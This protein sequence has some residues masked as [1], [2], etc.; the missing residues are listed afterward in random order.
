MSTVYPAQIDTS[1]TL[2]TVQDNVTVV[3]ASTVNTLRDAILA[4]ENAL[5]IQPASVY[6]NVSTRL[7][8]IETSL[9]NLIAGG[10]ISWGGDLAGSNNFTQIVVGLRG[11]AI[12]NVAPL[13]SQVLGW[14]G[15]NWLPVNNGGS[16][17]SIGPIG[18]TG[19]LGPTGP[20][21]VTGPFGGPQGSPGVTG[22]IGI[23]G[24]QGSPGVTGATG[25]VGVQGIQ[26][27]PGVTGHTGPV[28]AQ[29]VQGS[30][31]I[32]GA[33]GPV[34]SQGIQGI[35]GVTGPTG[36]AGAQ[37]I[38]GIQGV[39]GVTGPAGPIGQTGPQGIQGIQGVTGATGP[40]G[41][42]GPLGGG[43]TGSIGSTGAQGP[44]G[45]FN[46]L[47][48]QPT[49]LWQ[50]SGINIT[51]YLAM[52]YTVATGS[53]TGV[54]WSATVGTGI[55]DIAATVLGNNGYSGMIKIDMNAVVVQGLAA[56]SILNQSQL[57]Y[58]NTAGASGWNAGFVSTGSYVEL[59]VST[60]TSIGL[61]A[62][63]LVKWTGIIQSNLNQV[64]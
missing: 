27:S 17:G 63:G 62:T 55:T 43:A 57:Y 64:P 37:G 48:S 32:T 18:P 13:V 28:G 25:P 7:T 34:G 3:S 30:P 15:F 33:T 29:G 21:G 22:P 26:G 38:Q 2:T 31:G 54:L 20:Q 16:T 56:A 12:A 51:S 45:I 24:I 35:T 10:L 5:G 19:P 46:P 58:I 11:R 36:P 4:I 41:P 40:I 59:I 61:G 49:A 39:T 1:A 53:P 23:Q 6:G 60:P 44:T 14:D 50:S 47:V 8:V 42:T 52:A 9:N